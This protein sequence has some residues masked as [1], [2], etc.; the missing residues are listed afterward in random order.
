[1][2]YN[3]LDV[4]IIGVVSAPFIL[5]FC[6]LIHKAVELVNRDDTTRD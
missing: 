6:Y 3:L 2:N 4:I 1:M 5:L